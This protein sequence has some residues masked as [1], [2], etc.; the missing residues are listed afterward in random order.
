MVN[1]PNLNPPNLPSPADFQHLIRSRLDDWSDISWVDATPSTNTDL[2]ESA[3]QGCAQPRLLGTHLQL[4]GRGRAGRNF[5]AEAGNALM[6]SCSF[7]TTLP[8]LAL[9]TL[10]VT[11]GLVACE[12]LAAVLQGDPRLTM[13]WPND[14][15]WNDAKLAGILMETS[16]TEPHT[17]PKIAADDARHPRQSHHPGTTSPPASIEQ[18]RRR[19][20]TRIVVGMGLNLRGAHL[21]GNELNRPIA[22]WQMTMC[23]VSP[24]LIVATVANAWRQALHQAEQSWAPT[25][26]LAYLPARYA[27]VDA[28]HSRPVNVQDHGRILNSGVSAGIDTHGRLQLDTI[29]GR[30]LVTAG[31]IS[32]REAA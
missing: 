11:F 26:G 9:P 20:E 2:L 14:V 16:R 8:L 7:G 21:L 22:D 3:R 1:P 17:S 28:L 12:A 19:R 31:D 27:R 13:K 5:H 30:V 23:A 29:D 32:V 25:T 6:F 24:D 10:S 18:T 15:Q 4:A